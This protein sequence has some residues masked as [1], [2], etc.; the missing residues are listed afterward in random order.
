MARRRTLFKKPK[1]KKLSRIISLESPSLESP[2]KALKS[3]R[4]LKREFS[5]AK[6]RAKK[7]RIKRAT[8]LA[9]NRAD[10]QLKRKNLSVKERQEFV[11]INRIYRKTAKE[12]KIR[13]KK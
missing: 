2:E 11:F 10:A 13:P 7:V 3:T 6:Q 9:A 4:S 8:V 5:Q 1:S 12:F